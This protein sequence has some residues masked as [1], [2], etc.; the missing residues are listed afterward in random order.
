MKTD[1]SIVVPLRVNMSHWKALK[2]EAAK[3]CRTV[4]S[5]IRFLITEH[6]TKPRKK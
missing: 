2:A 4:A 5:I 3:E 6:V 1:Q